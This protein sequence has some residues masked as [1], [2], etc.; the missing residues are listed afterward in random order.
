MQCQAMGRLRGLL[1]HL[2]FA[3]LFCVASA[4]ALADEQAIAQIKRLGGSVITIGEEYE[5]D[6]HLRGRE[7]NDAG[8]V[9]VAALKNVIWLNLRG[10]QVTDAGM[11]HLRQLDRLR[12]L[13]LEETSVDDEGV[14]HLASLPKLEYL[15]L[16]GTKI[17][18]RGLDSLARAKNLRR[19]YIWRTD[20]T[21]AGIAR[22]EKALPELR[23]EKG[24]DL[25]K[26]PATFPKEALQPQ[27]KVALD[28]VAVTNRSDAPERSEN[29][30]NCQILFE[31]KRKQPVKLYWIMYGNGDLKLYGTI[32]PG[33]TREQNSYARNAWLVTDGNDQPLGYFVVK[34]DDSR[35]VIPAE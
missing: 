16:Y 24:V 7:L 30:I 17:T 20:V 21:D 23:I 22:L 19:L 15:N 35:A 28:W 29:G 34:E 31:N 13:H 2:V 9:H 32:A 18:D 1:S 25:S 27:P 6:F 12:A 33:G 8:L 10:T 26:L 14:A 4:Q 5:V 3:V 11:E